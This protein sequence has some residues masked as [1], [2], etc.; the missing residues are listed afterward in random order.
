LGI[1]EV[2]QISAFVDFLVSKNTKE[3]IAYI[4]A[5]LEGGV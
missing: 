5:M 3:G 4:N 2:S 1:V